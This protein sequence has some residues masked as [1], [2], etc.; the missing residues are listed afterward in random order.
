M[1]LGIGLL[2][3]EAFV[4]S[5]GILGIGGIGAFIIGSLFLFDPSTGY[6]LPL[7]LVLPTAILIG[8]VMLAVGVLLIKSRN[9]KK[10]GGY[11]DI[12]GATAEVVE[13]D[14]VDAH[15][16]QVEVSGEI[17]RCVAQRPLHLRAQVRIEG[18][19]GMTLK[20]DLINPKEDLHV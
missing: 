19:E 5:F 1:L 18:H 2:I 14:P 17:W 20:V 8:A 3:A 6:Q 13:V 11:D 7:S 10:H 16:G 15:V 12:V 4:P 9:V